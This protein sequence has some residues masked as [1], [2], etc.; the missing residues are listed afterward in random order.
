MKTSIKLVLINFLMQILG[1]MLAAP[2]GLIYGYVVYGRLGVAEV[3]PIFMGLAMLFGFLFMGIFLWRAGYL[4]NDGRL[5]SPVSVLYLA[6]SLVAGASAIFLVDFVMSG[7]SFLP[8]WM[9]ST[10][11]V[12]QSNV[13]GLLCITLLGPILEELLFRGAVTKVLLHKYSPWTA[14]LLSG[15]IFGIFHINPAQV[16]GACLSGFL[17]AWL[18]YRTGSL[19]PGILIHIL[20]NTLSVCLSVV[21]PDVENT[22]ELLGDPAYLICLL[23]AI[24]LLLLSLMILNKYKLP[25]TNITITEL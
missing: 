16:V 21:Y 11:D 25:D 1:A 9:H 17:F 19:I 13:L 14:I 5:Y 10:F 3:Q 22:H 7:L 2:F 15:L 12:L 18:Y 4:K 20:N 24:L 8:D 23:V 6:V